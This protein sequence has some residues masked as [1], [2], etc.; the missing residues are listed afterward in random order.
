MN[1]EE[2]VRDFI[3]KNPVASK[4]GRLRKTWKELY[5]EKYEAAKELHV[6]G[7]SCRQLATY[8]DA[9]YETIRKQLERDGLVG[10]R[11]RYK[12]YSRKAGVRE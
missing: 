9:S 6:K 8:F 10:P 2:I 7:Y 12:T 3:N 4:G 1:T 5:P 11:G